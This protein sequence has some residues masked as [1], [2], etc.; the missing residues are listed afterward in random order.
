MQEKQLKIAIGRH[1]IC[2]IP[3]SMEKAVIA[4]VSDLV[5]VDDSLSIN[6]ETLKIVKKLGRKYSKKEKQKIAAV[7]NAIGKKFGI[8][9]LKQVPYTFPFLS[10]T[11]SDEFSLKDFDAGSRHILNWT[12]G[13]LGRGEIAVALLWGITEFD[14]SKDDDEKYN[15]KSYDLI[16]DSGKQCDV[17]DYRWFSTETN[18]FKFDSRIRLG[19]TSSKII[20]DKVDKRLK[21]AL[22]FSSTISRFGGLKISDFTS[23]KTFAEKIIETSF[24][25]TTLNTDNM[26]M[27]LQQ[28]FVQID[29]DVKYA[30]NDVYPGGIFT[31]SDELIKFHKTN[32]FHI[33][34]IVNG[35]VRI[36]KDSQFL[37]SVTDIVIND[38]RVRAIN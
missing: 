23:Q 16:L 38:P 13:Q 3:Q 15:S 35:K 12:R 22:N 37:N 29:E 18:S 6:D 17:K 4:L 33:Y 30:L 28:L 10:A 14:K 31:I 32:D 36:T 24:Y 34:D 20:V 1:K 25:Q 2:E 21:S 9:T 7:L 19:A 8:Q 5:K 27:L 11:N 26:I